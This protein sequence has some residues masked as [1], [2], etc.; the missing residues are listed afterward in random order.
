MKALVLSNGAYKDYGF[1]DASTTYDYIVCADN[2]MKHARKLGILPDCI[3]GDL[4]SCD[5]LD[6]L[7]FEAKGVAIIQMP[8]QKD[9]TDTELA[10]VRCIEAG[11]TAID[12]YGGLGTRMD[13]SL[14]NMQLVYRYLKQGIQVVLHSGYNRLYL[15]DKAITLKGVKGR[16][17]SLM[18]Y[19]EEV[20]GVTTTG[21]A[22]PLQE[23]V[24][25]HGD[26]YGVSNYM[27]GDTATITVL[28]GV[29]V[30]MYA[31]D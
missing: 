11:A 10:I 5:R 19:T 15:V 16:L 9:E 2:G 31:E 3:V 29:L 30:V 27:L 26:A 22:Y 17:V 18:P 7:F 21:L 8:T 20:L 4:D 6:V 12:V 1:C 28:S 23:G 13:H 14:A 25:R 24:F